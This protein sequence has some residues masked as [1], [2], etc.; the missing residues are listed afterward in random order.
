MH[1][2]L[3]VPLMTENCE[4]QIWSVFTRSVLQ[5]VLPVR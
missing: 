5:T 3:K 1:I 2:K 4:I